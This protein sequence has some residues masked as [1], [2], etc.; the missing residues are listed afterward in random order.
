MNLKILHIIIL[1]YSLKMGM[2]KVGYMIGM[3]RS[4]RNLKKVTKCW[5]TRGEKV[6]KGRIT[7]CEF[8]ETER[9]RW[10]VTCNYIFYYLLMIA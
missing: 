10:A 2:A 5:N 7:A 6:E 3:S 4:I 9:H 1:F 8:T